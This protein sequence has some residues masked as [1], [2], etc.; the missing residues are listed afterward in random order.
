M[1]TSAAARTDLADSRAAGAALAA[2]ITKSLGATPPDVVIVFASSRH[3]HEELLAAIQDC[4]PRIVVGCSSAGEFDGR[5]SSE[6]SASALALRSTELAFSAGLGRGLRQDLRGA[7]RQMV[8]GFHRTASTD[9]PYR[10]AL[11]LTDALAGHAEE[12]L[13]E[14]T[15]LTEGRYRFVGGGAGDDAKFSRTHVFLGGD[16]VT[17]AAVALEIRSQR[18]LGIGVSHGWQPVGRPIR[19]TEARGLRVFS[20][21]GAPAV[22]TFE[23]F[24]DATGQRFDRNNALPF[25][26]HNVIG[27]ESGG[28]HKLRVPLAV[29]DDGSVSL[30]AEVPQSATVWL[31]TA[32]TESTIGAAGQAVRRAVEQL[33]GAP[34]AAAL[35]F[36]CAATRLRMG[37]HFDDELQE[38]A[39]A[40][41]PARFAGCNTYGQLA[42]DETQFSGFHN[43]TAVVCVF[44]GPA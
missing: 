23:E 4:R 26:L 14:L 22:E 17:D 6:G 24:A 43:C 18:P 33:D 7:A 36:D 1:T 21:N 37:R 13:A 44:P 15:T 31:M 34:A 12:L 40:L 2:Q 5:H 3:E 42:R 10:T 16:V 9:Y 19:V 28:R 41:T 38:V 25:F 32:D 29:H 8:A 39:T 27:I 30:A 11:V 35:F 20:L